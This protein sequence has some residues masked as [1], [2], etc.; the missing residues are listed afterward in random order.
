MGCMCNNGLR[1]AFKELD[2]NTKP[3]LQLSNCAE[4]RVLADALTIAKC[5]CGKLK[6]CQTSNICTSIEDFTRWQANAANLPCY[7]VGRVVDLL[8]CPTT[9]ECQTGDCP[10][11]EG[12]P[13]G[14]ICDEEE[15][16][17]FFTICFDG[18]DLFAVAL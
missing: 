6:G 13:P 16:P 17:P 15:E 4:A 2:V 14:I 8:S 3:F 11:F 12:C 18:N 5:A 7:E 1:F 10:P 9:P